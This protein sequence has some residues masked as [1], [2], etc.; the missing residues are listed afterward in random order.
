V[1]HVQAELEVSQRRACCVLGQNRQT[2]R[3]TPRTPDDEGKLI[4]SMHAVVRAH[5]RYGYRFV[6]AK[7]RQSGWRVNRK[8]V[9]RLWKREGLKVPQKRVK[10]RRLGTSQNG[11]SRRK[12]SGMNDV[13]AFDFI[14]DRTSNGRSIKWLSVVDEFTRECVALEVSRSMSSGDV[15]DVLSELI[16]I[17]GVPKHVRCDNGPEFIAA[18]LR[19]WLELSGVTTLYIEPASPWQN[20][21]AESFH[22]RL[23]D[24]LLE[25]EVFETLKE[26]KE[27][28]T[29]WRL[30]YNHHRPH[31]SLKYMTPATFAASLS[32][33]PAEATPRPASGT[34]KEQKL[35][36]LS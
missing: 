14:F 28:A 10:R 24:E 3:H 13:W 6:W 22:S 32:P 20:G 34:A 7:L 16:A 15:I 36:K 21:Y 30:D 4:E 23:R 9:Y 12:A 31:S 29:D 27:L 17:R 1:V 25:T 8:R 2:Q 33:P 26:A 35:V 18:A 11:I 5:P 19:S